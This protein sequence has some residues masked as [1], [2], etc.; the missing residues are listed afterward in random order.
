[1]MKK[2]MYIFSFLLIMF[3]VFTGMSFAEENIISRNFIIDEKSVNLATTSIIFDGGELES[4]VPPVIYNNRTLVPI[5]VVSENLGA[6]ISWDAKNAKVNIVKGTKNITLKI[7]S[8]KVVVS[9][10]EKTL[11][12]KVPAKLISDRT[13]VP[14]KFIS[15]ELGINVTWDNDNRVVI[16]NTIK[17]IKKPVNYVSYKLG[18]S[19]DKESITVVNSSKADYNTFFLSN[20]NRIVMDFK[21]SGIKNDESSKNDTI[22]KEYIKSYKAYYYKEENR[23]RVVITFKEDIDKEKIKITTS[24]NNVV[25]LFDFPKVI[26]PPVQNPTDNNQPDVKPLPDNNGSETGKKYSVTIDAGHGGKDP[27]A[28]S[29]IDKTK[30]KDL[31]LAIAQRLRDKLINSGYNTIMTRDDDTFIELKDRSNIANNNLSDVFVSIHINAIDN[32]TMNGIETLYYPN[33]GDYSYGRDNASLAKIIQ[34]ELIGVTGASDRGIIKRPNL[35]V[36]KY[37]NM[38]AVLVECGFVTNS[39]EI[40]LLNTEEYKEKLTDAI[41][42][43]IQKYFNK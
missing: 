14:L 29:P 38:P 27:G 10:K 28:I 33:E 6:K 36:L 26:D 22:D 31:N 19:S 7:N 20:P 40:A 41:L 8:S 24:G 17:E 11:P 13:M 39:D 2:I 32:A 4:D 30:E 5:R 25:I 43:G 37:T 23:T 3:S 21:D 16:M 1:M 15:D 9:G 35:V 18:T 34:N 12:D 42:S